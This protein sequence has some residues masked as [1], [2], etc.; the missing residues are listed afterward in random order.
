MSIPAHSEEIL[1]AGFGSQGSVQAL[2]LR[3]SGMA[4]GVSLRPQSPRA[5]AVREAGLPLYTNASEAAGRATI[6]A[7]LLPDAVQPAYYN[8]VLAP[9]LPRGAALLFAHGFNIHYKKISPRPDLDVVLVAPLA[10][11]DAVRQGFVQ[12]RSVPCVIA[13]AQDFTGKARERAMEYARG[14]AGRGPF[15]QST[16]AEETETDLFAEQALLCGG[17][18]ELARAAF[19]SLVEAGYNEEIAYY[20]CLRE[21]KPIADLIFRHGIAGMRARVSDTAAY[22]AA[23]RGPRIIG[24]SAREEM[25]K[26]LREI[27]SNLFAH[28]LALAQDRNFSALRDARERDAAHPIERIHRRNNS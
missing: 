28:E 21:L 1:I 27:K 11:A 23:T 18:P 13:V 14:I 22:G 2:N 16:F 15:I 24:A 9:H 17:M 26:V 7:M 8:D 5:A 4:V 6:A 19:E 3:D 12:D 10:H 20:C 25:K